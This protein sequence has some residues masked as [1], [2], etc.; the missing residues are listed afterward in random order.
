M[1]FGI[2]ADDARSTARPTTTGT[3]FRARLARIG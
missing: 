2:A 3:V 1:P